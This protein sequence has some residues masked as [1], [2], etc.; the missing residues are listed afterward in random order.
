MTAFFHLETHDQ[1]QEN[2]KAGLL[3]QYRVTLNVWVKIMD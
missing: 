1:K 2:T 3:I